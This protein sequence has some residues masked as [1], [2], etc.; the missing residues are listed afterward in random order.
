VKSEEASPETRAARATRP[1]AHYSAVGG[2]VHPGDVLDGRFHITGLICRG[3]M[4]AIFSAQDLS[5]GQVEVAVKIPDRAVEEKAA[6]FARFKREEEIGLKLSH[7]FILRFVHVEGARSRPYIVT[8]RLLGITLHERL[9]SS[10]EL[11]ESE[12]LKLAARVCEALEY[13]REQGAVHRDLKPENI[14]LCHD[15]S[16]RLIDFGVARSDD[17][18]RLTFINAVPG[19]PH[20][21]APEQVNGG[22][23]DARADLYSLGAVLYQMLT[24]RIAFDDADVV[25]VM[26]NRVTGDPEAPRKLN[27][28]L[29]PQ[30]EEIVLHAMERDPRCRYLTAAEMKADLD[31]PDRVE[32]TGRANR[33]E[34]STPWKRGLRQAGYVACWCL[35]PV[36]VQV[37]IFLLLW[38][39][40]SHK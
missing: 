20:Y 19:T 26:N 13:L 28:G 37:L 29:S 21:M 8:E 27:P 4:S 7:P 3:G 31:A 16:I 2:E 6:L 24:G 9:K 36:A 25:A 33:L 38:S 17:S 5:N 12:A 30:A 40:Y 22:R 35:I 23:C 1:V 11:G 15:G 14:M 10:R 34:V 39:H 32:V 18:R